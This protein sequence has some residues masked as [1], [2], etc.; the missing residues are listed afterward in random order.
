MKR[1]PDESLTYDNGS[2]YWMASRSPALDTF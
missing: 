2:M 1:V